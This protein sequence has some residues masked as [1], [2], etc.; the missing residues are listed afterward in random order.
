[1]PYKNPEDRPSYA[2][3]EQKPEII[4]KRAARNKARAMLM[5]EGLVHKGD[6]KDVDHKQPLSKGGTTK[7]SNLS[8]KSASSNRSFARKSDHSIK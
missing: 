5:K 6:G 7:R 2:K 4:K 3:Y 8:V 1:M